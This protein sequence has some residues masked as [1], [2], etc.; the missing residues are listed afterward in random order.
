MS[1]VSTAA[2]TAPTCSPSGPASVPA[3][4]CV[5]AATLGVVAVAVYPPR[6]PRREIARDGDRV[7]A[8]DGLG[9]V[10]AP[11][12]SNNVTVEQVDRRVQVHGHAAPT[13]GPP[14]PVRRDRH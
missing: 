14:S 3:A 5:A 9:V 13:S 7:V 4:V 11:Q 6:T 1:G 8:V 2:R 12:E 10:V